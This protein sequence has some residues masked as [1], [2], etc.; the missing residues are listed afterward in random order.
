MTGLLVPMVEQRNAPTRLN[1]SLQRLPRSLDYR[2]KGLVTA[3]KD[4]V[5]RAEAFPW[6][7]I[8]GDRSA[9]TEKGSSKSQVGRGRARKVT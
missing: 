3:V 5:R 6:Q 8:S 1:G 4:Q 2:K 9:G 7:Q